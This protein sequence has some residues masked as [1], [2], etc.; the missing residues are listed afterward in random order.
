MKIIHILEDFTREGGGIPVMV[1]SQIR[2]QAS[3]GWDVV[4]LQTAEEHLPVPEGVHVVTCRPAKWGTIWRWSPHLNTSIRNILT[5][6]KVI[7][8]IHGVWTAPQYL[9]VRYARKLSVPCIVSP[10][11]QLM[12][13]LASSAGGS[14]SL[15]KKRLYRT[16]IA[17]NLLR[18]A[19]ALHAITNVEADIIRLT[20]QKNRIEVI[21]HPIDV[22]AFDREVLSIPAREKTEKKR[23]ILFLGRLDY[24][25]GI[26]LLIRAFAKAN[27]PES[28]QLVIA[29]PD[30]HPGYRQKISKLIQS[31][32]CRD[33]IAFLD[34]VYGRKKWRQYLNADLFCLPSSSEVMGLVNMEASLC[35]LPVL[36]TPQAGLDGW[37][38]AGGMLIDTNLDDWVKA[39]KKAT[40][41]SDEER[42]NRGAQLKNWVCQRY[43]SERIQCRWIETYESLL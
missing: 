3:I 24:R 39:L 14:T 6:P 27:P 20:C 28:W 36:T 18:S 7:I 42:Q 34:P 35:N 33:R 23:T 12:P 26:E 25:K 4:L 32:G 21:P 5:G 9:A 38:E 40:S 16:L 31:M 19:T 8:H 13:A 30:D 41:W 2:W 43:N 15:W 17:N 11:G 10:H 1:A 29:G 22:K 37:Q